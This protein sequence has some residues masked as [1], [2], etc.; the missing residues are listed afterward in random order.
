[1]E[2]REEL[3]TALVTVRARID[4]ACAEAGRSP[5]EVTLIVITKFFP[6]SDVE[7][8]RELGVSDIGESKDQEALPKVGE[9]ADAVRSAL[10]VH[11]V[12]QLQTNKANR[13]TRYADC[14]Q[15]VDRGR[16]VS[17]LDKG[18]ATA[19][20][21]G[22]R[23]NPLAVTLQVGLGEGEDRGR[24]GALPE[25]LSELADRVAGSEHL[26]LQGLM[27]VAPRDLDGNGI[28]AAF[29]R[30][31]TLGEE[32]RHT[33]PDATWLSAGMSGDLELAIAAGATHLR[34]GSA[35]LGSRPTGR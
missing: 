5:D 6:A 33:H 17:A 12:G 27:A 18:V 11:F 20:E 30:L 32:L 13:V 8:L 23:E 14:V 24:G 9:L 15:S 3:R 2:R 4:A 29:D 35:I 31:A 16:L 1:M 34:V 19:M 25:D 22:L 10:S 26:H 7:L 28:R 21:S